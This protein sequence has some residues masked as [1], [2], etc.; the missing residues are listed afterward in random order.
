MVDWQKQLVNKWGDKIQL[1]ENHIK[2]KI[3]EG[4]KWSALGD[5]VPKHERGEYVFEYYHINVENLTSS[6]TS[7]GLLSGRKYGYIEIEEIKIYFDSNNTKWLEFV[8]FIKEK[9]SWIHTH[10]EDRA[11]EREKARDYNAAIIIW[12]ALGRIEEAARV[13]KLQAEMGSVKVAQSVV[14]GDQITEVKDS[15]VNKS[16]IGAGGDDKF[17]KLKELTEM[18]EKGF[19]DDDEF[20]QMKKEILEK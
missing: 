17:T 3:N 16:N 4:I 19:I 14:Q 11:K 12:E 8:N 2:I 5:R 15:V 6:K 10:N 9:C 18:K 1:Y 7:Y 20:K 13:R